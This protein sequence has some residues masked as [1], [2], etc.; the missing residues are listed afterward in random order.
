MR[1]HYLINLTQ[2]DIC[3]AKKVNFGMLSLH[4]CREEN[5]TA[6]ASQMDLYL[7]RMYDHECFFICGYN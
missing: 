2:N 5:A 6:N 1:Y 4:I 7:Y 3:G